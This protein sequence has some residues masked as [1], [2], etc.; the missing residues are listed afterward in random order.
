M[1]LYQQVR[2]I[3]KKPKENLGDLWRERL[4]AWRQEGATVRL[5]HPTRIDRARSLGFKAKQGYIVVRK[6]VIRGGHTRPDRAGGRR[7]RNTGKRLNLRKNY[8]LIAEERVQKEYPNLVVLN[9]Y[10]VAEDGHFY[11]YEIILVDPDHPVI[12]ADTSIN[13]ICNPTNRS[14]VFH[15][16][17]SAGKK[18]R[19]MRYKGKGTE[20]ARPSRRAH[21]RRQ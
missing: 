11:W 12:K 10:W 5:E 19:G 15:G 18:T 7:S 9:S 16:K 1:G 6:R 21:L 4:I 2:E 20:K 14:R 17:T 3:W 13:W 8:Q